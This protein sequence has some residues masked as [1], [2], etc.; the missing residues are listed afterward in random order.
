MKNSNFT[1]LVVDNNRENLGG[2]GSLLL[3]HGYNLALASDKEETMKFIRENKTDL[4]LLDIILTGGKEG[5]EVCRALKSD[6]KT[7]NIPVIFLTAITDYEDVLEGFRIGAVDYI[8]KP[9]RKEELISRVSVHIKLKYLHD[10]LS[11]T[12]KYLENSRAVIMNWLMGLAKSID[13]PN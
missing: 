5:F 10:E 9:F 1:V 4:I 7:V 12:V 11:D 13:A 8:T 6:Q 3:A 2:V